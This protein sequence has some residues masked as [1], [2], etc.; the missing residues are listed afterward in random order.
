MNR[1]FILIGVAVLLLPPLRAQQRPGIHMIEHQAH[2]NDI[3]PYARID[4]LARLLPAPLPRV[5]TPS[6]EIIGFLPYW[7]Y[8]QYEYLDYSLLTQINYFGVD[9]NTDGTLGDDHHWPASALIQFAH[10]RGVK[11]S[12]TAIL[13]GGGD[14]TTLL[15]SAANRQRLVANLLVKVQAAGG[16]GINI[17]FELLPASQRDNMVTFIDSLTTAFHANLPSLAVTIDVPAVDWGG[18]WDF[19]ALANM[20]DGLFIMA[21]DYHWSSGPEAGPVSP[22]AGTSPQNSWNVTRTV[23][24]YLTQTGGNASKLVLGIPYY[25]YDWPVASTS[26]YAA[27]TGT[28]A[29]IL[30]SAA[31]VDGPANGVMWDASSSTNWYNYTSGGARQVWYDDS[32]SLSLKYQLALTKELAG[33]GM[34]A[35]SYDGNRTEL[36]GALADHFV[37]ETPPRRPTTWAVQALSDGSAQISVVAQTA[38]VYNLY[39]SLDGVTF[40]LH[41]SYSAAVFTATGL[42][43]GT[44]VYM[45]LNAT[46]SLGSSAFSDVLGVTTFG[47]ESQVLIVNGF[48]RVSGTVNNFDSIRRH[49]PHVSRA[50]IPFDA[51]SNEAVYGGLVSL[52]RYRAVIWISGEEATAD[53][54]FNGTEQQLLAA[55]VE[56]GGSL[57]VSGSEIG[58]DLVANGSSADKAFY[59]DILK[60]EYKRDAAA[61]ANGPGGYALLPVA[62][63][64]LEGLGRITFDDGSHGSY[65]VDWPDGIAPL[66]GSVLTAS[67]EGADVLTDGAAA[68]VYNGPFG[69][70]TKNG[71]LVYLAVGFETLYPA[72]I[73]DSVM[74]RILDFFRIDSTGSLDDTRYRLDPIYPNPI[75]TTATVSYSLRLPGY[76][77]LTVY[78]LLGQE[79]VRLVEQRQPADIYTYP[80]SPIDRSG[81]RLPSGIYFFVLNVDNGPVVTRKATFIK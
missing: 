21:Y 22:L 27:T 42:P 32:L 17:D 3:I 63:S 40:S 1:S 6:K 59:A 78:N 58:Y 56:A 39:L 60:A 77:R 48:D 69:S 44:T 43:P 54:S 70:S 2:R 13:F 8:D 53:V 26:I 28:G 36:W 72:A 25:G 45:K 41:G 33:V 35:L 18:T 61:G 73:R 11:V 49:G 52:N 20:A 46:N 16:D 62:G 67:Y 24:E 4:S 29:S 37:G 51:A 47:R 12:L 19:A 34:W 7:R 65:N 76:V 64:I 79:V 50:G 68:I 5:I 71:K 10:A 57:M 81:R 30:Y 55:F 9:V 38:T 80:Y 14:L 23:N 74:T 66:G 75:L 31:A 15:G